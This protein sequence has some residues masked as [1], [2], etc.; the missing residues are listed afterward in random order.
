MFVTVHVRHNNLAVEISNIKI[1]AHIL[2]QNL[3]FKYLVI[4]LELIELFH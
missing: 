1:A 2:L 3:K 4:D